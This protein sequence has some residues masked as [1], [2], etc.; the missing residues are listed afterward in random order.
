MTNALWATFIVLQIFSA[1]N[2]NYQQEQGYYEINPI[3]GMHPSKERVYITK[4]VETGIVYGLTK[5]FPKHEK[6]ILV[7]ANTVA[8]SFIV[9]DKAVGIGMRVRF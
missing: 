2:M 3:Y 5:L 1:G 6:C 8:L 7:G 9:R 4:A